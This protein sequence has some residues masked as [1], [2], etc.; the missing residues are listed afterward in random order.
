MKILTENQLNLIAG[1]IC[2]EAYEADVPLNY[3]PI[4][5]EHLKLL[6][7]HQFNANDMLQ[8]LNDA[9][10]DTSKVTVTV[11]VYCSPKFH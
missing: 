10:L 8:A 9:G 5:A 7:K 4:V 1:G 11:G 3:L 6:N 2:H